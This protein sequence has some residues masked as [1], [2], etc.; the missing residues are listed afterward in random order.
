MKVRTFVGASAAM[1]AVGL[2]VVVGCGRGPAAEQTGR[3]TAVPTR[4]EALTIAYSD[5]PGWLVWEIATQKSWFK[6]A[7]VDVNFKWADYGA[8]IDE[9]SAGK[10]DARADRLR[11]FAVRQQAI[12]RHRPDGL[13]QWQRHDHRQRGN[14]SIKDIKGKKIGVEL[15][16]VEH[17]LLDKALADNGSHGERR[18]HQ[19]IKTNETPQTLCIGG[20]GR[21]RRVVPDCQRKRFHQVAGSKARL[22]ERECPG[23]IY[24]ALQVDR[25]S[26]ATRRDDWK[27]VV[28]VWFRCLDFLNDPK[29]HDDAVRIMAGRIENGKPDDLEKHLKGTQLL[30]RDEN[31]KRS[32][33]GRHAG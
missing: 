1:L 19:D 13:L 2:L 8:T 5:W 14:N 18:V 3:A 10:V 29:T 31:L 6:E 9:Y 12:H 24:D 27:K 17:I 23:L 7:G 20:R 32:G 16:L 25:E 26:L 33:E 30:D 11:R 21:G 22:H 28:G 4:A 15:N